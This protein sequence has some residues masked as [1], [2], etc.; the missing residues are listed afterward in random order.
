MTRTWIRPLV[1]STAVIAA[2]GYLVVMPILDG[3]LDKYE[4][5]P[6]SFVVEELDSLEILGIRSAKL[7]VF[8]IF[9]YVGACVGSFLNVVA[10]SAP[11]GQSIGLRTSACPSCGVPIRRL[12]NVPIFS[13]LALK[14]RCRSCGVAIPLRYFAVE[15]LGFSIFASLF[16]FELVNGA[17]NVPAF[18]H[19]PHTGIL[20]II[21]YAKWP[22]IGIY[23]F[24][25][26]ML[27]LMLTFALMEVDGLRCPRWMS[28]GTI[29]VF[30]ILA[31]SAPL[32][33]TVTFDAKLPLAL[34]DSLPEFVVRAISCFVGGLLGW[35]AA[36]LAGRWSRAFVHPVAW[37]L[38][39]VVMGWQATLTV[40]LFWTL[41]MVVIRSS[42]SRRGVTWLGPTPLLFAVAFVHHPFWNTL[43]E[44]W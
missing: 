2:L 12:D 38:F 4:E 15:L 9:S 5:R 32:L 29:A 42:R 16:L 44:L 37:I 17:A 8:A 21:L 41:G 26:A 34:P 6:S 27:C 22:V 10:W 1:V 28:F 19:Y 7:F 35:C 23:C 11:H 43:Y 3:Y 25:V 36:L 31:I 24:H 39:G 30:A 20:W 13:Y 40:T 14:G 33:H 18:A